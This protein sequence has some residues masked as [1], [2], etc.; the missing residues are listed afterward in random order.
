MTLQ[1]PKTA[2][3][4][5]RAKK[6]LVNG[7]S[8]GWRYWGEGDTLVIDRGEGS[9]LYDLDDKA[10]IDY[11]LGFGP[12]ILGHAD[13]LVTAA[14]ARGAAR[15]SVFA[16]TSQEEVEAAELFKR[17]VPWVEGLR[18]GNTGTEATMHALRL[19]RGYTGRD[20]VV[21]FEGQYHGAHD[22]V[23]YSTP[24][25]PLASMGSRFSPIAAPM[26]SGMPHVVATTVRV[27][28]YNDIEAV[29]RLF[30]D[31][32]RSIA[33][34]MVEPMMGN[35]MGILPEPGFLEGLRQVCDDSGAVLIFDEVKTGFRIAVGG[36]AQLYGV[37]P[38]L[39]TY[40]KALGNG[41]P[42]AAI[43]GRGDILQGWAQGGIVQAG[44]FSGNG[45]S[46][47]AATATLTALM[48]GEPLAQ[49]DHVG[50][51]LMEGLAKVMADKGLAGTVLG[52][53][54]MFSIYLGDGVPTDLRGTA[55]HDEELYEEITME[56]IRRGVMPC[57]D[58]LEPWFISAAHTDD[59]VAET[60]EVF[61]AAIDEATG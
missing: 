26:S 49:V 50:R 16:M 38:D 57:P 10:Y 17:A 23:M 13:P 60:L 28:P 40:A 5:A 42:V 56:M 29:R 34:I 30:A 53:P 9:R 31:E 48:T 25:Q 35:A 7:V 1:G 44:T 2:E 47:A 45:V 20:V 18:F 14:A 8:S 33:A 24:S 46:V 59:D 15:G 3:G 51:A 55:G 37:T 43:A 52:H 36:A 61:G 54:S 39:G 21:K 32:G 12:I 19:A 22:Y 58:A 41:V 11:I 27:L 6:A 4:F